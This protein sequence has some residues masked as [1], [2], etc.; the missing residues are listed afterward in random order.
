MALEKSLQKCVQKCLKY[1]A[2]C[3]EISPSPEPAYYDSEC[4]IEALL[5]NCRPK[6]DY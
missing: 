4:T 6:F 2:L 1:V 3:S 5:V